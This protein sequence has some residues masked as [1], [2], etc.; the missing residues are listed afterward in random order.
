MLHNK[1]GLAQQKQAYLKCHVINGFSA[2]KRS[3]RS[4]RNYMSDHFY[5]YIHLLKKNPK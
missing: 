2:R 4:K 1:F 5:I 3:E